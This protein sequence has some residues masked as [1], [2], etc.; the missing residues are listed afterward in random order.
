MMDLPDELRHPDGPLPH[1]GKRTILR[2]ILSVI[3]QLLLLALGTAFF[4]TAVRCLF[5]PNQ[6][7][8]GG[9]AGTS[10]LLYNLLRFPVGMT[11]AALNVPIF[12]LG[13]RVIGRRFALYSALAVAGTW[14]LVD[15]VP[16][17]VLTDDPLLAGVFGGV[18]AGIGTSLGLK[19]GGSLGGLD[20][21]GT[22]INRRFGIGVGEVLLMVNGCIVVASGL[23]GSPE[24]AMYT[25]VAI[26]ASGKT[27][28]AILA[29]R[30]RK[31]FLILTRR[32]DRIREAVLV[33]MDRGMTVFRGEGAFTGREIVGLLCVVTRGEIKELEEI[34]KQEDP[35]AFQ[36]ILEASEVVGSFR[37]SHTSHYFRQFQQHLHRKP[38]QA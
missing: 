9:V 3:R 26:F 38:G 34:V 1:A 19:S 4:V 23:I 32:P 2:R 17:P 33:R 15:Y 18:F 29:P 25:L 13:F 20:I 11:I 31:A 8:A 6:L 30:H 10:L 36:V 28:D 21:L 7:L 37:S 16:L 14:L 5:K 35:D 22:I 12:I 24:I 27:V